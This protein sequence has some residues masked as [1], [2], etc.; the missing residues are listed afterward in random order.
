MVQTQTTQERFNI[1]EELRLPMINDIAE[2]C[3]TKFGDWKD[4]V[5]SAMDLCILWWTKPNRA[6][7]LGY[8]WFPHF[9]EKMKEEMKKIMGKEWD[10]HVKK[11]EEHNHEHDVSMNPNP[12]EFVK[13]PYEP[14]SPGPLRMDMIDGIVAT[15]SKYANPQEFF[16]ESL[17][18]MITHTIL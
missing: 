18:L 16:D 6:L 14:F 5:S 10:G 7:D 17:D 3:E 13:R 8:E 9:N 15:V 11:V 12:I 1:D 4:F 2:A